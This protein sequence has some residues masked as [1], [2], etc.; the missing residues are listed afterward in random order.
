MEDVADLG[1][2]GPA[3]LNGS[4]AHDGLCRTPP[5]QRSR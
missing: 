3:C 2:A 5:P 1:L 4:R